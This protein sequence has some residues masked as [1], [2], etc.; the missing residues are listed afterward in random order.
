MQERRWNVLAKVDLGVYDRKCDG[1]GVTHA[2]RLGALQEDAKTIGAVAGMKK[3]VYVETSVVSYFAAQPSRD[4]M[5]AGHQEA[6]RELWPRLGVN[7]EPYISALVYQEAG[8]GDP[9][10]AQRRLGAI[11]SFRMLAIDDEARTL[12]QKII[13]GGG[14]PAERP[15]DALHVAVAAA[16]GIDVIVTW[17]FAH[18]NNPFT[19]MIV[20]QIIENEGYQCPEICSPD[21]L[22]EADQ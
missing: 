7:Y 14:V 11:G 9:G 10:Q 19:R 5:I 6:T 4:L 21:E 16:N 20:R 1:D 13:E 22:L 17:N 12:A 15:E 8:K 2:S 3:R 18:L